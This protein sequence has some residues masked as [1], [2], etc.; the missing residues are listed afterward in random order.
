MWAGPVV[1]AMVEPDDPQ[2]NNETVMLRFDMDALPIHEETG[3]PFSSES[4][5]VMHACGHDG[6]TAI[7]M[8]VAQLLTRHRNE[9]PGRV[10]LV[11]SAGRGRFG[12]RACHD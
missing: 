5:G 6:H 8:G 3:L 9:L 2:D 11:F 12:R 4:P 1:I 7:G 10:K